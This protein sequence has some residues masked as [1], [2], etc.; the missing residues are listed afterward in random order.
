MQALLAYNACGSSRRLRHQHPSLLAGKVVDGEDRQMS[1]SHANKNR[2]RYRYYVTRSDQVVGTRAWRVSAHDL[3]QLVCSSIAEQLLN[4]QFVLDLEGSATGAEQLQLATAEAHLITST[5][6][7]GSAHAKAELLESLVR[8]VRLREDRVEVNLDQ[9]AIRARLGISADSVSGAEDLILK[10][11]AVR[12]RR[13][14]QLRLVVPG[15]ESRRRQP[16]R[17]D[18]RLI[19]LMA[20]AYQARQLV[21]AS[22]EH[23][24]SRIACHLG[25]CRTRLGKLVE[26]SCLAPDIIRAIVEGKQ[27]EHLTASRLLSKPLPLSW[28]E[29]RRELG[30]S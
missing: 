20:D 27:P 2:R 3:E 30:L 26:L 7:S 16:A 29:Q 10:I 9:N 4:Q 5:L 19:A 17:R 11:L 15:A 21:L 6:R 23:S 25:R 22:P 28:T 1:P 13:G 24:L 8:R 18:E 14:H 12:I